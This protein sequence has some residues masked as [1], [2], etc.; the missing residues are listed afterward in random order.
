MTCVAKKGGEHTG[1]GNYGIKSTAIIYGGTAAMQSP[2]TCKKKRALQR[3]E[4]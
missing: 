3:V 1:N 2:V 4:Q